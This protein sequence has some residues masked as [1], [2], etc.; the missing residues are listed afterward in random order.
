MSFVSGT[1]YGGRRISS[2]WTS[3]DPALVH[4]VQQVAQVEDADDVLGRLPEDGEARVRRLE[5]LAEAFLGRHVGGDR[6]HF[7]PRHHHVGRLLV[8]E[9]EDLV[10]H[11]LLL[12]FELAL[13]GRALEQHLQLRLRVDGAFGSRR[14]QPEHAQRDLARALQEPDQRLEDDEE[15][16]HRRRDEERRLLRVA[17]RDALGDELA[18]DDVEERQDEEREDHG[19]DGRHHRI[20]ELGQRVLAQGSDRQRGD[21]DPELHRGDEPWRLVGEAEDGAG[22]AVALVGELVHPRPAYGHERVL[23]RDEEAVQ[24]H[25]R[26]DA[27]DLEEEGHAAAPVAGARVLGGRSLSKEATAEYRRPVRRHPSAR[28]APRRRAARRARASRRRRTAAGSPRGR[29]GRAR[30]RAR[31]RCEAR[32]RAR[33]RSRR[34]GRGGGGR[35][36]APGQRDRRSARRDRGAPAAA[37]GRRHARA[38]RRSRRADPVATRGRGRRRA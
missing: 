28:P 12:L 7:G 11:L 6:D 37:R 8:G 33:P 13:D 19:H 5:H 21:R 36:R 26:R 9:V 17:E 10:E 30:T 2:M 1:M 27:D 29:R 16:P 31:S 35:S 4:R 15:Q 38:S 24:Q 22:P 20:E 14:L 34:A 18:D 32:G 23:G 25:E 3:R